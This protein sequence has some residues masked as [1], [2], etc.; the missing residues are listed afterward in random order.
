MEFFE[1]SLESCMT[2]PPV[3]KFF[4]TTPPPIE[5]IFSG[6]PLPSFPLDQ[7]NRQFNQLYIMYSNTVSFCNYQGT[8]IHTTISRENECFTS[9]FISSRCFTSAML[10][11]L[12]FIISLKGKMRKKIKKSNS[13]VTEIKIEEI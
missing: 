12:Y 13:S 3:T 11:V 10:T 6:D 4:P 7:K 2:P 1:V 5:V 8:A 9:N